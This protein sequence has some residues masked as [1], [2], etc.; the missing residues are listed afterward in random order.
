MASGDPAFKP[1]S[2]IFGFAGLGCIW[3]SAL[4][5][6]LKEFKLG[7]PLDK[8]PNRIT[9][10]VAGLG[11][12]PDLDAGCW[13][14]KTKPRRIQSNQSIGIQVNSYDENHSSTKMRAAKEQFRPQ[15]PTAKL[16]TLFMG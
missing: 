8:L 11:C 6:K 4:V 13:K 16:P 12:I 1:S 5:L 2:R 9:I 10:G 15:P 3:I 14:P 7:E